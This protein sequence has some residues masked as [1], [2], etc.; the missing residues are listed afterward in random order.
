[1]TTKRYILKKEEINPVEQPEV[2]SSA[3]DT[4]E[5]ECEPDVDVVIDVAL[6]EDNNQPTDTDNR[7]K[8]NCFK[9]V[10]VG[11]GV[12]LICSGLILIG[13]NNKYKREQVIAKKKYELALSELKKVEDNNK[14]ILSTIIT[15]KNED[16][17][18]KRAIMI[19][20]ATNHARKTVPVKDIVFIVDEARKY[21]DP[22]L[23]L[24]II[25]TE[26]TFFSQ[27]VS[28]K[29][30]AGLMQIMWPVWKDELAEIGIYEERELF[31]I[32]TNIKAG[33]YVLNKYIEETGS[34]KKA[35]AKYVGA[36]GSYTNTVLMKYAELSIA[37]NSLYNSTDNK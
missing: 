37:T 4:T 28:T 17:I 36:K 27:A 33:N 1:M 31:D 20:W 11:C 25:D 9:K 24:S 18:N 35:L 30:A 19:D 3:V 23:I 34:I 22:I 14:V 7:N 29:N 2:D 8:F 12:F 5:C 32:A 21:K 26:S 10:L 16:T 13:Q 6:I 15:P